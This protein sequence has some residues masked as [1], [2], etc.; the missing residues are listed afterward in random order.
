MKQALRLLFIE[1]NYLRDK[2]FLC[3]QVRKKKRKTN[4]MNKSSYY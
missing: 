4:T 1:L 3:K 2:Q